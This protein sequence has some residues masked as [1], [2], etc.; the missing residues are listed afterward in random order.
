MRQTA[1]TKRQLATD[2]KAAIEAAI[3]NKSQELYSLEM[4]KSVAIMLK[5]I[6]GEY[7]DPPEG[8]RRLWMS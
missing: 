4:S 7:L 3:I 6:L 8:E 2:I 5:D 1:P